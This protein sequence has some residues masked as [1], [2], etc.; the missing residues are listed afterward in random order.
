MKNQKQAALSIIENLVDIDCYL[1]DYDEPDM[2]SAL[3]LWKK[4][5]PLMRDLIMNMELEEKQNP[6]AKL[7]VSSEEELKEHADNKSALLCD[8]TCAA[9]NLATTILENIPHMEEWNIHFGEGEEPIQLIQ[10]ERV[11]KL[12]E[13]LEIKKEAA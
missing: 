7:L 10:N 8:L 3:T 1:L 11:A 4:T 5:L 9:G 6:V 12:Q 2:D 13:E